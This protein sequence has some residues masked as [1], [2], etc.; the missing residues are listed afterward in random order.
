MNELVHAVCI[1]EATEVLA[2]L[3]DADRP[4]ERV[5]PGA[6]LDEDELLPCLPLDPEAENLEHGMEPPRRVVEVHG[7]EEL[8]IHADQESESLQKSGGQGKLG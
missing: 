2:Q 7:M 5:C 3:S 1:G 4:H 6:F 8:R